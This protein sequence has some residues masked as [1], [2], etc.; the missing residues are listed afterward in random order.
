MTDYD[1]KQIPRMVL[2]LCDLTWGA[3]L[4]DRRKFS[5]LAQ[6]GMNIREQRFTAIAGL[7]TIGIADVLSVLPNRVEKPVLLPDLSQL[8]EGTLGGIS[9]YYDI[10]AIV[11]AL[12]PQAILEFGTFVGVST[13]TMALNSPENCRI[14]TIDLPNDYGLED[15]ATLAAGE[16]RMVQD[17]VNRIGSAYREHPLAGKITELRANSLT[18]DVAQHI[19]D[20]DFCLIDGGHSYE[21]VRADTINACRVLTPTGVI[22]WDDFRWKLPGVAKY[23]QELQTQYRLYRIAGTNHVVYSTRLNL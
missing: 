13:L 4:G 17:S 19:R 1:Y 9:P 14:L 7:P 2:D 20:V 22:L 16:R 12:E 3:L 8:A 18:I 5:A 6:V 15:L 23:L 10:G 21:I 11:K